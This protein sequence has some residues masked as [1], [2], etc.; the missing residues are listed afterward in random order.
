MIVRPPYEH[1]TDILCILKQYMDRLELLLWCPHA[2]D[3]YILY[4]SII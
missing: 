2:G 4:Y 1:Y 3:V